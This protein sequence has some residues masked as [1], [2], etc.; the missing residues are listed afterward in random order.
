MR[1]CGDR[2]NLE[3]VSLCGIFPLKKED[4]RKRKE[5]RSRKRMDVLI[6]KA[7]GKPGDW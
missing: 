3:G 6:N 4:G 1:E 2:D 5:K 7:G